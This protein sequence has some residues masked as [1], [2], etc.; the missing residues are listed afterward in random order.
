[1]ALDC[2]KTSPSNIYYYAKSGRS[3]SGM[4]EFCFLGLNYPWG[5]DDAGH[6]PVR[7]VSNLQTETRYLKCIASSVPK[8]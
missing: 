6:G 7:L 5:G 1:M 8:M 4:G 2:L 3:E